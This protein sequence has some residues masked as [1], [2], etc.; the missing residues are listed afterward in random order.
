MS[1]RSDPETKAATTA[2]AYASKKTDRSRLVW[3]LSKSIVAPSSRLSE[4]VMTATPT[5]NIAIVL[6]MKGA[7]S[8]APTATSLPAV[9]PDRRPRAMAITGIMV[10]GRAVPTAART[11]PVAPSVKPKR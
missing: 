4:K 8:I 9:L 11:L 6:S 10:S 5:R 1:V 3:V 7:P 2:S